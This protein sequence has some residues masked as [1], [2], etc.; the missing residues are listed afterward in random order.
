MSHGPH[1]V[2]VD[3]KN[4]DQDLDVLVCHKG[5]TYYSSGDVAML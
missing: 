3:A 2:L 1:F 5:S 4:A